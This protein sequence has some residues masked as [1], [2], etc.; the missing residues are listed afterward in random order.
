MQSTRYQTAPMPT[1]PT[2]GEKYL[3]CIFFGQSDPEQMHN[4]PKQEFPAIS[5]AVRFNLELVW[6][7]NRES[8]SAVEPTK[9]WENSNPDDDICRR[10]RKHS[11]EQNSNPRLERERES[12]G[13]GPGR[14]GLYFGMNRGKGSGKGRS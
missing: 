14:L 7:C 3:D 13:G 10:I 9:V 4:C 6:P 5:N 2:E 1:A 8:S 12:G 11:E